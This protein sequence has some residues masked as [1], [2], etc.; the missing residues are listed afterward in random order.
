M[1]EGALVTGR[2]ECAHAGLCPAC[3]AIAL[4]PAEQLAAKRERV[5]NAL[6]AYALTCGIE[7][8][9]VRAVGARSHYR[10]RAKWVVDAEGRVGL[11]RR[12]GHDV[13]DL[14]DCP[15]LAPSV[16][17]V[18]AALREL[19]GSSRAVAPPR[20]RGI[21]LREAVGGDAIAVLVTL[22]YERGSVPARK[23]LDDLEAKLRV[24][25]G[26]DVSV[27]HA[28]HDGGPRT[29]GTYAV[30]PERA[31]LDRIGEGPPFFAAH[32]AF[33]QAHREVAAAIYDAIVARVSSV[34]PRGKSEGLRVLELHAGS[35]ALALRLAT[36]GAHVT[37]VERF[38]PAA[39]LAQASAERA[40]LAERV[41]FVRADALAAMRGAGSFDV[42]VL[43][44]P[45]HGVGPELRRAVS[46]AAAS[47]VVYV[48]C[49]PE[50]LAR[51]LAHIARLG[52]RVERVECFDMMPHTH[53]VEVV[54]FLEPA[55]LVAPVVLAQGSRWLAVDKDPHEPTTPHPE[56]TTSTVARVRSIPGFE[57]AT[58]VHRLDEET[59]GV[60][61]FARTPED[62]APLQAALASARK[63][64]LALVRGMARERGIVRR[65]LRDEGRW[66]DATTRYRRLAVI[67][68]HA[69]LAVRPEQ[70]RTHQVRRHLAGIGCPVA[71]DQRYGHAPTNRHLAE[72]CA[73][74]RTFLHCHCLELE[75]DGE[76]RRFASPLASDLERVL[77]RL[78]ARAVGP[79]A[80]ISEAAGSDERFDD[81]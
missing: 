7:A 74:D 8:P 79:K 50:T 3:P 80:T 64:Y 24:R 77:E 19:L 59:S 35:G 32:G 57:R 4:A 2:L 38:A 1:R 17:R 43:D 54:A 13:V 44:P 5:R 58:P 60:C 48:S 28:T 31:R 40:G 75:V 67:G 12:G 37:A 10:T 72:T 23:E 81:V 30:E 25:T 78:R 53:E 27:S 69:L 20:L 76:P 47:L 51:D 46:R 49:D 22:T 39:R 68:G 65:P 63:T 41:R 56:H 33:V 21:D 62:V 26:L 15:V 11:Y 71:G 45:R 55:T 36:T 73:L 42:V 34:R 29:L 52:W 14:P 18:D 66:L 61:L 70:G 6:S 9:S 16:A